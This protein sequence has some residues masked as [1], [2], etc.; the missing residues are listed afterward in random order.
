MVKSLPQFFATLIFTT[1]SLEIVFPS[2]TTVL[3]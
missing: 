2:Q 3:G 1:S